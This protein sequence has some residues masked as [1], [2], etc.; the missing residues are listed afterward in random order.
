MIHTKKDASLRYAVVYTFV[1]LILAAEGFAQEL[2][3][4][5]PPEWGQPV[6]NAGVCNFFK[7][8]ENV[9]RSAQPD[10]K[11]MKTI[12]SM[13][14]RNVLSLSYFLSDEY[15][16]QG[17]QLKLFRMKMIANEIHEEEVIQALRIIR[18][19]EGP[20]LVHC[21]HGS[22]RTGCIIAMYRILNQGWSKEQA[23]DEMV[24]G[25]YGFH[26]GDV[27]GYKNIIRYIREA[28]IEKIKKLVTAPE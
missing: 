17:T 8:D 24:N 28:D 26:G 3:R 2:P 23:I 18:A 27:F 15:E 12:E 21:W 13:G 4:V 19:S 6:I 10:M 16:A 11:G 7:V 1:I 5:R 20:I 22:D 9:Y 14:I 25:G